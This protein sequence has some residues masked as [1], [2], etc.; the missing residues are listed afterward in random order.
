M[1]T[2]KEKITGVNKKVMTTVFIDM[3]G[4]VA[5]FDGYAHRTLGIESKPGFR[6]DQND[7][8][9]LREHSERIYSIIPVLPN[10]H[11][12][13][14]RLKDLRDQF[15]FDMRFLTAV[16][17]ENDL[18]WAFWDKMEW[19]CKHFPGIPVW[20]GPYSVDKQNHCKPGDILIDDRVNN[21][22][23]WPEHGI[24]YQGDHEITLNTVEQILKDKS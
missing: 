7:W 20:F 4:V 12:L 24:L 21:I 15:G 16:P 18:G 22:E 23:Q 19:A 17:K 11:E 6:F 5:D 10:A 2:L 13:I 9:R 8:Y 1:G 14:G 3:D